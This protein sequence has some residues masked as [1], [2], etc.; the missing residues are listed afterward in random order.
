MKHI[1]NNDY[2]C[3]TNCLVLNPQDSTPLTPVSAILSYTDPVEP[4]P[5]GSQM[6]KL[7]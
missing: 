5:H 2:Y 3:T 6:S 4:K 1:Y 7:P